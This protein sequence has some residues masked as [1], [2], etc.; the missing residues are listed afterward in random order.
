MFYRVIANAE[1]MHAGPFL[2]G[3]YRILG[4]T[5]HNIF[6]QSSTHN[7]VLSVYL[8]I[9]YVQYFTFHNSNTLATWCVE[10]T[11]WKRPWCWKRLKV[12]GEGEDRGW[13]GWMA[14]PTRWTWVW[15]NSRRW[16]WTG[17]PGVLQ[18]MGWQ[19]VGHNW[20]T[21]LNWSFRKKN[22]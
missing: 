22:F 10:P 20:A 7:P 18:S 3:K 14:S 9:S 2:L 8:F 6:I 15:A 19:R 11:H 21:E 12:G 16:W 4:A 13:D 17:R 1:L 5:A